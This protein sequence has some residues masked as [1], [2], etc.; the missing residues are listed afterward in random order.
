MTTI[1]IDQVQQWTWENHSPDHRA[2]VPVVPSEERRAFSALMDLERPSQQ[3][4]ALREAIRRKI[5]YR[6]SREIGW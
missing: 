2:A 3:Q 6:I 4:I 1:S 5:S